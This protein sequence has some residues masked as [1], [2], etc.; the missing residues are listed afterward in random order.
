MALAGGL[1]LAFWKPMRSPQE[2]TG[3]CAAARDHGV[4]ALLV[5][6]AQLP[7]AAAALEE[8]ATQLIAWVGF[9]LGLNDRDV[10][11]YETEVAIDLGAQE[12]ELVLSLDQL[13]HGNSR[14]LLREIHDVVEA[15]EE[16]PVC[17]AFEH[18]AVTPAEW[19]RLI[20][21][22]ADSGVKAVATGTD[23]WPDGRVSR[24]EIKALRDALAP[25]ISL[26][27]VGN[28]RNPEAARELM[29]AGA[30]RIGT[31]DAWFLK[32]S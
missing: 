32:P 4:R 11:R 18:A 6:S 29:A 28:I 15:A 21:L 20:E 26:K 27:A 22:V 7:A 23:F 1:E 30:A 24:E 14:L 31:A 17:V 8:S 3:V 25:Q 19:T 13:K 2:F 5:A 12:I 16:R 10:K 9:P